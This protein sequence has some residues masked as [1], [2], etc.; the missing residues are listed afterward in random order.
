[1]ILAQAEIHVQITELAELRRS[2]HR[3]YPGV[4]Q[5]V[6]DVFAPIDRHDRDH[7]DAQPRQRGQHLYELHPVGQ[8]HG[9]GVTASQAAPVQTDSQTLAGVEELP[10]CQR[11]R[12]VGREH[13]VG[14]FFDVPDQ[15]VVKR[16]GG[17]QPRAVVVVDF[18]RAVAD[19]VRARFHRA[20]PRCW[21][22]ALRRWAKRLNPSDSRMV[23]PK[24]QGSLS[25]ES[26]GI[27]A[28]RHR[29]ERFS[30]KA[31]TPS[32]KSS[33]VKAKASWACR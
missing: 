19:R 2:E 27:Y 14:V 20:V 5:Y 23:R 10:E 30:L 7:D 18:L 17:P 12:S 24:W 28:L 21:G 15:E 33:V 22:S 26:D 3:P 4:G 16:V 11:S 8:L 1:M 32:A 29:G 25:R 31:S 9:G 13:L 6:A